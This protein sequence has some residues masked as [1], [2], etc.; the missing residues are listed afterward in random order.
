MDILILEG[1]DIQLHRSSLGRDLGHLH[2]ATCRDMRK[3]LNI[4]LVRLFVVRDIGKEDL[5]SGQVSRFLSHGTGVATTTTKKVQ[6]EITMQC[7]I[8][9]RM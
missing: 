2:G 4:N 8:A 1:N 6:A 9:D 7:T 5:R 3:V